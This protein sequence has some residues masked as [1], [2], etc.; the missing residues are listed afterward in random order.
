MKRNILS[1][2]DYERLGVVVPASNNKQCAKR[3]L[4][5][6]KKGQEGK[7]E[8]KEHEKEQTKEGQAKEEAGDGEE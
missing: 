3:R 2:G 5:L 4:Q 1:D 7:E 6:P 8:E